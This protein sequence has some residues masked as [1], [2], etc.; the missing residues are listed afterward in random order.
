MEGKQIHD[1]VDDLHRTSIDVEVDAEIERGPYGGT[2]SVDTKRLHIV[3]VCN[4]DAGDYHLCIANLPEKSFHRQIY[5]RS[6]GAGR[7]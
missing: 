6:I 2:R 4:E 3:G 7:G 5:Q 1:V